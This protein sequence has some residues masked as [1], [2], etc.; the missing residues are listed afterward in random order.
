MGR[1]IGGR[2]API[3]SDD[4]RRLGHGADQ[5][6]AESRPDFFV[7]FPPGLFVHGRRRFEGA[8]AAA[9]LG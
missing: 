3:R 1:L 5:I 4:D 9:W 6:R 7:Q 8:P 2:Q